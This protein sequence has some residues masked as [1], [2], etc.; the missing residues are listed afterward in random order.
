MTPEREDLDA[1]RWNEEPPEYQI[2]LELS[3][4]N[5]DRR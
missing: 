1:R 5:R 2:Y 3:W 4:A